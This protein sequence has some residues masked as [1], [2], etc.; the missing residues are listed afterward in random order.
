MGAT[1]DNGDQT[2]TVRTTAAAFLERSASWSPGWKATV[3]T[4]TSS[5][6]G[7]VVGA[8]H[9]VSVTRNGVLQQVALPGAGEYLVDFRYAPPAAL[10]GLVVSGAAAVGLTAWAVVEGA[11]ILRRR[12]R[13]AEVSRG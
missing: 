12:R 4:I 2:I 13:R 3:Q 5:P 11:G 8:A 7:R 10:D 1:G 6:Q 9:P